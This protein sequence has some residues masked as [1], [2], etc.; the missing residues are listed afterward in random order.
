MAGRAMRMQ[1]LGCAGGIGGHERLTTCLRVDQDILLDAGTGITS[2]DIDQLA[3]VDHV[4]LTHSHLDHVAGLALLVDAVQG[5]RNAPV[6]VY[7]TQKVIEALKKYLFN[8]VLWPDFATIPTPEQPA[9]RWQVIEHEQT[10]NLDGR[11][12]TPLPVNHTVGSSA[13]WVR[14]KNK[15]FLF[16]GDMS[17]T[18]ELWPRIAQEKQL[19]KVIIDCSFT[20]ADRELADRSLHFCP[21]TLLDEIRS[22]PQAIEFLIYHLKPGQE[23]QIMEELASEGS[24]RILKALAKSDVFEF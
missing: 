2:L 24:D 21:Q 23:E 5:R 8:W 16:T 4:F 6:T 17:S 7:A 18:P 13:Y 19:G 20:N 1:V 12:I 9:M 10:I 3:A 11:L 14:G 22:V 15:G